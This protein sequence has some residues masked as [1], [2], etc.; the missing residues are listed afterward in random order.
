MKKNIFKL[1]IFSI[2]LLGSNVN[3]VVTDYNLSSEIGGFSGLNFNS[4]I[5]IILNIITA[6]IMVFSIINLMI[7][8]TRWH[9]IASG[10]VD[11]MNIAK[12]TLIKSFVGFLIIIIVLLIDITIK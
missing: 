1:I 8:Y 7:G 12:N 9:F 2:F 10:N 6:I 3:A 11:E 5:M 4:P